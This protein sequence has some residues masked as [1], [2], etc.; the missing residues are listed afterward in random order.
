MHYSW[1]HV[2]GMTSCLQGRDNESLGVSRI[3]NRGGAILELPPA[4][5]WPQLQRYTDSY[6]EV[7]SVGEKRYLAPRKWRNQPL[8]QRCKWTAGVFGRCVVNVFKFGSLYSHFHWTI[9]GRMLP[10]CELPTYPVMQ[11]WTIGELP[12]SW[13][14][15]WHQVPPNEW[16]RG[17][18]IPFGKVK[19]RVPGTLSGYFREIKLGEIWW[20]HPDI[21]SAKLAGEHW[22]MNKKHV[23]NG[24]IERF[25][26]VNHPCLGSNPSKHISETQ[27]TVVLI[28]KSTLY[29]GFK[30]RN[31]WHNRFQICIMYQW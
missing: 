16:I 11:W 30:P 10:I 1:H 29:R 18:F 15:L 17:G 14:N 8:I 13:L 22:K 27:M 2:I 21:P 5:L 24:H 4:W 3:P 28:G 7:T 6:G 19:V 23:S 12:W 9:F 31:R 20:I 25:W 26:W